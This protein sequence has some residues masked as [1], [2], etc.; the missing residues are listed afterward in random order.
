MEIRGIIEKF[1]YQQLVI[2]KQN[3]LKV[4]IKNMFMELIFSTHP[5]I[6]GKIRPQGNNTL[7]N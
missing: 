4:F 3:T 5:M 6:Y 1:N 2:L 7:F